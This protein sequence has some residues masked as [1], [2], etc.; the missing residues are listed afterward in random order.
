MPTARKMIAKAESWKYL[1]QGWLQWE[2]TEYLHTAEL[3]VIE[4]KT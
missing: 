2:L 1:Y 3:T 4:R